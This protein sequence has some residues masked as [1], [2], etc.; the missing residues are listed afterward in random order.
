MI[1]LQLQLHCRIPRKIIGLRTSRHALF[2]SGNHL[3]FS[4]EA[5]RIIGMYFIDRRG[6]S[7]VDIR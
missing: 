2:F 6:E 5:Y 4:K 3:P 1:K 7:S